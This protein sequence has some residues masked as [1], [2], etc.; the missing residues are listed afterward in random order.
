MIPLNHSTDGNA[1]RGLFAVAAVLFATVVMSAPL[2]A[3]SPAPVQGTVALEGT[4]KSFYRA[5]NTVVVATID[6]IE[7]VYHVTTNLVVHGGKGTGV[8]ALAGL[9]EGAT[10]VVHYTVTLDEASATEI[11]RIGDEGLEITEGVVTHVDRGRKQITIRFDNGTTE[12]L[13]LTDRAAAEAG[14]ELGEPPA[15]RSKIV[16][17]YRNEGGQ[18]VAHFFK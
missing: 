1:R 14:P 7:H 11:D 10:V 2:A 4:M 17:Y 3:Q 16:V 9:R 13:G 8:D 6:G 12:T 5:A 15:A 18:K